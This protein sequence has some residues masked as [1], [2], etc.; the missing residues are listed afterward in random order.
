M[1][2]HS[3]GIMIAS[4]GEEVVQGTDGSGNSFSVSWQND[5]RG[6]SFFTLAGTDYY[7]GEF[8]TVHNDVKHT[9]LELSA[10]HLTE[11]TLR[12]LEQASEMPFPD[13]NVYPK[14]DMGYFI[15]VIPYDVEFPEDLERVLN[16]AE[17]RGCL[18]LLIERDGSIN[19][20]L[21]FH[22]DC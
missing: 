2:R 15:T 4:W 21:P 6:K 10:G 14:G 17:S 11:S 16:Y 20:D 12:F 1:L 22:A 5:S 3:N 13:I 9:I 18:Y 7:Q 8:L 19:M